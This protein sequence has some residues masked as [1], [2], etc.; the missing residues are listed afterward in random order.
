MKVCNNIELKKP[1]TPQVSFI[2][3]ELLPED[4]GKTELGITLSPLLKVK[5]PDALILTPPVPVY[6]FLPCA[7]DDEDTT[8]S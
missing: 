7:G 8:P 2:L 4:I 3:K 5:P 1:T 6:G